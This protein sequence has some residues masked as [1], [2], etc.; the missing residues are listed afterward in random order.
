MLLSLALIF[1]FGLSFAK[2]LSFFKIPDVVSMIFAGI[3][4]NYANLLDISL[5]NI[6]NE[7]RQLALVIIL[8]RAGLSL[9]FSRLKEVG[10]PVIFLSFLPALFEILAVTFLANLIFKIPYSSA[11]IMGCVVSAVSPAIIVPRMIN[12]Q[13]KGF[14]KLKKIPDLILA[15][16][17]VDDIFVIIL[18]YSFLNSSSSSLLLIPFNLI[19]GVLFGFLASFLLLFLINTFKIN[20]NNSTILFL[21]T[22]FIL[23]KLQ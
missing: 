18:F 7:L 9:D 17:S 1:I 4:L 10:K 19:F 11:V 3:L 5:L 14:G 22:S 8:T 15:G 2:I 23:L 21:S 6:S 20:I 13:E 12:L 16:A